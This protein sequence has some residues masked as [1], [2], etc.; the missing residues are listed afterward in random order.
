MNI[1][2]DAIDA[3]FSLKEVGNVDAVNQVEYGVAYHV[4]CM[5]EPDYVMKLM[6]IY[7]TLEPTDKRTR[8]KFKCGGVMDTKEFMY[9]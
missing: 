1:K 3:H 7:G 8:K 9:T 5:K 6:T 2:G 4:F